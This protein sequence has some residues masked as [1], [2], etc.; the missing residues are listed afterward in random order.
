MNLLREIRQKFRPALEGLADPVE[1]WLAMIRPAQD[2]KFGDFQANFAMALG[3][4]LKQPPREVAARVMER[5]DLSGIASKTEIAGPGF[6]NVTLDDQ[7]IAERLLNAFRDE[8]RNGVARV[9]KPRT[10][11]VDFSSPNVAK[12][13]H[14]GHIRSTVIGD[15]ISRTLRFLG[16][17]VITDNHLGDWG[18]QFGM[19]FYG[20]KHFRDEGAWNKAPVKE[21]TRLYRLVRK[22]ID[23]R[24]ALADQD[25]AAALLG[26][27]REVLAGLRGEG[28]RKEKE[29]EKQRTRDIKALESKI[30]EQQEKVDAIAGTI[31][32]IES[33]PKMRQFAE[34]HPAIAD[35][36]L[37]ETAKLHEGDA[38]NV[39]L[40]REFMVHGRAEME[41]VYRRLSIQFDHQLGE[42]WYHNAL[43]EVVREL[44]KAGLAT[45][46]EGAICVFLEDHEAPM[47]IRKRDGAYLYA[48]TDLATIRYR[49]KQFQPDAILYVVDFR[50]GDHFEKLFAVARKWGHSD[51]EYQHISFGTVM[52]ED[53][54]PLKTRAGDN[55]GLESLIDE[56]ESRAYSVVCEIDDKKTPPEFD[57]A[58]RREIARIVGI[59]ALKYADLSQSRTSDYTFSYDKMVALRGNTATYL[60]YGYA[61]AHGIFRKGATTPE[62]V[63]S[64][65]V[66]FVFAEP[67]ERD[68][69]IRLLRYEEVL[70]ESMVDY[71]PNLIANY[72]FELVQQYFVFFEK[73][74]VLKETGTLRQSRL[75]LCDLIA[76]IIRQGLELL[77]IEAVDRM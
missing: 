64:R 34:A 76:R 35:A 22:L 44:E 31:S 46:S 6:I 30:A 69:A 51:V 21:L 62:E 48:T 11:V 56:A 24:E 70:H 43:P 54:K 4:Q 74:P 66:P 59:S 17:I 75:Q 12:P 45:E 40:W 42:S 29:A 3:N 33:D 39:A 32:A 7:F 27:Q 1:P 14:V 63:R 37:A 72:L 71:R 58:R 57:E 23:Y 15:S 67:V 52:G 20:Y 5:L 65:A 13:M 36:V 49:M 25:A 10:F 61:R 60:Q 73:C 47:I 28:P 41:G 38:E 16:H 26:R 55:V 68:L 50:Q 19:I 9:A 18:T 2:T 53:G 77:G 8:K